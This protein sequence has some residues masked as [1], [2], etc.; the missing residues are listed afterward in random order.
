MGSKSEAVL[1]IVILTKDRP[2]FLIPLVT[3]LESV[4]SSWTL[5]GIRAQILI[6]DTGSTDPKI[7]DFYGSA[8]KHTVVERGLSYH[9]SKN[10][11]ALA[12]K[13]QADFV[14]FLN[15]DILF[16]DPALVLD[17]LLRELLIAK[18][19]Q[20]FGAHMSFASGMVQHAGIFFSRAPANWAL[21]YHLGAGETPPA[22][23]KTAIVPA[24]TGAFLAMK[25]EDFLSLGGFLESYAAECQDVDL[26]LKA[27]RLGGHS[28]ILSVGGIIH[29][30][31]G[32]RPKGEINARDR[33][34]FLRRWQG[35]VEEVFLLEPLESRA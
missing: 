4:L 24:V 1:S 22:S 18:P 5:R 33:E 7:L 23:G 3:Q 25:R 2:E 29:F 17:G 30:E 26:C 9:F 27:L 28:K 21:P 20:V 12:K 13:S 15:N 16:S 34:L 8:L 19:L 6:G 11:N 14:L 10:N 31:N 35:Y 32:T